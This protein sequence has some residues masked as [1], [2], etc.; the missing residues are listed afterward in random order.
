MQADG[1]ISKLRMTEDVADLD[2][3]HFDA[4][5]VSAVGNDSIVK[6]TN[7]YS[8]GRKAL[9]LTVK[10][11]KADLQASYGGYSEDGS[12]NV[13]AKIY[14]VELSTVDKQGSMSTFFGTCTERTE[15]N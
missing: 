15:S 11:T 8:T 4:D 5:Y 7:N 2:G 13:V 1:T 10:V 6:S 14:G 9:T 3:Q 12:T